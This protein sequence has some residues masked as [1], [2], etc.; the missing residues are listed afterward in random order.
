MYITPTTLTTAVLFV[1]AHIALAGPNVITPHREARESVDESNAAWFADEE[2]WG[3][4]YA[5]WHAE[6]A[7]GSC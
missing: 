7:R 1:L 5:A 6:R 4:P 2:L 3:R